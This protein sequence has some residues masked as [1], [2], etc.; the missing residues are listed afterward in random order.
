MDE[1]YGFHSA[2]DYYVDKAL[3]SPENMMMPEEYNH[4]HYNSPMTSADHHHHH[5]HHRNIPMFGSDELG[6]QCSVV[7][8]DSASVNVQNQRDEDEEDFSVIKAK[9]ASHPSYSKLLDA[10]IDCQKVF[11]N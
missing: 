10:Y 11:K 5:H 1:M 6:F 8:Q 3:M 4:Y 7:S 9:I 2:G